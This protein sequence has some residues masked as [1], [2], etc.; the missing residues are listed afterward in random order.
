MQG[1]AQAHDAVV[2]GVGVFELCILKFLAEYKDPGIPA[3][4]IM[5]RVLYFVLPLVVSLTFNEEGSTFYGDKP[6]D[7]VRALEALDVPV[8][9]ANCSHVSGRTTSL[10]LRQRVSTYQ[11]TSAAGMRKISW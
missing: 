8:I 9:G 6:E 2:D 7:V 4:I 3:A 11:N 1:L 10:M 5:F